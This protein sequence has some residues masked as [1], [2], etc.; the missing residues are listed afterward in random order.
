[1][2][3]SKNIQGKTNSNNWIAPAAQSRWLGAGVAYYTPQIVESIFRQALAGDLV[4]QW[5]MF[6]LME[7]TW[8]RLVKNLGQ[9]K[10][11][12]I[13][14][15]P[16][17]IPW[18]RKSEEPSPDAER[19]AALVEELIWN[20]S[21]RA[22]RDEN[23]FEDTLRDL[24]DAR[25]KG[26]SVLEVD[27]ETKATSNGAAV[28]PRATRWVHPSWY[29]F[30]GGMD[31]GQLQMRSQSASGVWSDFPPNKFLI[32]TC[33]SRTGHPLG[34][35]MLHSLGFWWAASNLTGD[36]FLNL[37]QIFGQPLRWATYSGNM[38][39]I[40]QAK[41]RG[42]LENM[43]SAAWGMFPEG[44]TFE[45][46]EALKSASDNPQKALLDIADKV[47]DLVVLRQTLTS[48]VQQDGGSRALGE[49][50][51]RVLDGVVLSCA[52]WACK[53]LQQL[54]RSICILN[55]GDTSECPYLAPPSEGEDPGRLADV[56]VK[57]NQAGLDIEDSQ[58]SELS[59]RLG[60]QIKRRKW[61]GGFGSTY[62]DQPQ[63]TDDTENDNPDAP[64]EEGVEAR[65]AGSSTVD[66]TDSVVAKRARILGAAYRG[67][68]A[69][70]RK[71]IIESKSREEC[72][73]RLSEAYTDWTPGR[74]ASEMADALELCA[75][76]G[77]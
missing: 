68:M 48:D 29:G 27:W 50:H 22:D 3:R 33:K 38:G 46:K 21:P 71:I 62:N 49:V 43:G 70:F 18:A 30:P 25:G 56:L 60:V 10:D 69:P 47:C 11:D 34:N 26:I 57:I 12:V 73:A 77:A 31:G 59:E 24:L 45:L 76:E 52:K 28:G 17:V 13:A 41:L 75:A 44:T 1:M 53:T 39:S 5:E 55:F 58:M 63:P 64:Q 32:G 74:L 67:S 6:D 4:S 14:A 16:R 40:E 66:P 65:R 42:M 19:R 51:E 23:D 8:P 20:M 72:L 37:A 54:V 35:A 7:A 9:L 15:E 61:S 2:K 36:W